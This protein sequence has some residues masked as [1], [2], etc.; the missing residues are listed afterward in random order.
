M[1]AD[2]ND[3]I[4]DHLSGVGGYHNNLVLAASITGGVDSPATPPFSNDPGLDAKSKTPGYPGLASESEAS[5]PAA[6]TNWLMIVAIL[7]AMLLGI[8]YF[9][10]EA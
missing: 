3:V 9:G 2:G 4:G 8:W 1:R 7:L 5:M 6:K 10:R